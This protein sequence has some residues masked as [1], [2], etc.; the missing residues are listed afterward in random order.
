MEGSGGLEVTRQVGTQ[1]GSLPFPSLLRRTLHRN[2]SFE[3]PPFS[4]QG[5]G[6]FKSS[7]VYPGHRKIFKSPSHSITFLN[8][9]LTEGK[10]DHLKAA[11]EY[12]RRTIPALLISWA[13]KHVCR[14]V[15]IP[16]KSPR[17]GQGLGCRDPST[18]LPVAQATCP[19]TR[20]PNP[21]QS[22]ALNSPK[23]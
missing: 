1:A 3:T 19:Q 2:V 8:D 7:G 5:I 21:P 11:A 18:H 20:A 16:A 22:P 15:L 9:P 17:W 6:N 4:F 12:C 14:Q 10:S 13:L 23:G